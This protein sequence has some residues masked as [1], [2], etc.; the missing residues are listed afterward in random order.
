VATEQRAERELGLLGAPP[1]PAGGGAQLTPAER[2]VAEL[3]ARDYSNA[4]ISK[5]LYL[6]VRTVEWH[7]T[8]TYRKLGL[9]SRTGLAAALDTA[10]GGHS[11]G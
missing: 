11:A 4:H 8:Q 2:R 7:L 9:R 6:T 10:A 1:E 5:S 3:A